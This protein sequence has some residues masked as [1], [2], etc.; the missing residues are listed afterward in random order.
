[1]AY[2]KR[3]LCSLV[4]FAL[5]ASVVTIH[6]EE[7]RAQGV[8]IDESDDN[9]FMITPRM[10]AVAVPGFILDIWYEQHANHWQDRT[11]FSYGLDFV[12]RKVGDFE[13]STA[14]DYANLGMTDA[15]W[16]EADD[17]AQSAE[18]TEIDLQF[19]S[20]TFSGFW[21][22]DV[23]PWFSPYVGGGLGVGTVLGDILTSE[24]EEDT[25]CYGGLGGSD[26][27]APPDCFEGEGDE[28]DRDQFREP[29]VEDDVPRILPV[30]N[31]SGGARF[32]IAENV[33]A[34]LELGFQNYVFGGIALGG[35][36]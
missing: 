28:F 16:Q 8:E 17:S 1:M 13:I 11:N 21:Y 22:W 15:M 27:F 32:N 2:L 23:E 6:A 30:V 5:A 25:D 9:E 18:L 29:E 33:V 24:P 31:L 26:S 10:R 20:L 36:W 14:V 19:L 7:A 12:W 3:F 35:Q 34:K 4:V